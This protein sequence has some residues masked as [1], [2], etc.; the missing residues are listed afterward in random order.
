M[1]SGRIPDKVIEEVLSHHDIVDVVGKY[2][3]LSKQGHYLKGLC[4]FHS[5]KTPS[6]TV[7]PEKQ[8]Y[9]CFGCGA[10]GNSIQFVMEIEGYSFAE[11]VRRLAVDANIEVTWDQPSEADSQAGFE[12]TTLMKAHE[13]TAKL[14][15]YI[16]RNTDQGKEALQYVRSRGLSDK[17]IDTFGIGYA[18]A[19][20]D[21]LTQLL[22]KRGFSLPLMERGGLISARSE[23]GGFVDRFR[24]RIIFPI[25]DTSGGVIAF[26]GRAF[27]EAQP[28]YLNS[29]ETMLFNKSRSLFHLHAARPQIRKD[30]TVIIFE[31]FMDVIKAWSAGVHN[32]VAT[33]GTAFTPE[34]AD[35]IR[36]LAERVIICYDGDSAGQAAAAK[37]IPMLEKVNCSVSVAMIPDGKDPDEYIESNGQD[38]F[39]R[40]IIR[41]AVPAMRFRLL[42]SRKNYNLNEEGDRLRYLQAAVEIIGE[43]SSPLERD[44]YVKDLSVEFNE[45]YEVLKHSLHEARLSQQKKMKAGDKKPKRWNNVMNN[46]RTD[47]GI[48]QYQAYHRAERLLLSVMMRSTEV[49]RYVQE[50]LGDG[51]NVEAHAA[52]A[53]YLYSYYTEHDELSHSSF[54]ATLRDASLEKLASSI[55][56]IE[57]GHVISFDIID[58]YIREISNYGLLQE[59]ERKKEEIIRAEREGDSLRAAQIAIE[60]ISLENQLAQRK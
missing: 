56:I 50:H 58:D 34:Q 36:R 21:T 33:M 42:H 45:S 47:V 29:P 43:L 8:I 3:S 27:G 54:L 46:G 51:F 55:A 49:C 40:E 37:C 38:R 35:I 24:N 12:R 59:I 60:K 23:G 2:V 30:H 6:F 32:G 31:G 57:D 15:Q 17:M 26:A 25:C 44:H 39:V 20:W 13:L 41:G 14:Y 18:P 28:K 5:E 19:N 7:T 1:G 22:E 10:G 53:A 16:L 48:V 9:H 52:L 11:A 4:P